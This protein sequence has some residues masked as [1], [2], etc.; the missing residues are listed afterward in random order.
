MKIEKLVEQ[1][2][3]KKDI[4]IINPINTPVLDYEISNKLSSKNIDI[5]TIKNNSK[6]IDYQYG[7]VLYVAVTNLL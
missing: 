3:S 1:G 5:L 7:N 6:L 4:V 2:V